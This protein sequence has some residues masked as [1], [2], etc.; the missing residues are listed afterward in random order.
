MTP[1]SVASDPARSFDYYP[2]KGD[3]K[4]AKEFHGPRP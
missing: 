4:I 1:I 3:E 2:L